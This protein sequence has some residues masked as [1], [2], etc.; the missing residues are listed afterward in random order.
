V[1]IYKYNILS[2]SQKVIDI[3]YV[4]GKELNANIGEVI[5]STKIEQSFLSPKNNLY[6]FNFF[7]STFNRIN[8]GNTIINIIDLDTKKSVRT[9]KLENSEIKDNAYT[10]VVFD[11]ISYSGSKGYT[12][13]VTSEG[14]DTG[15]AITFWTDNNKISKTKLVMNGQVADG[16]LVFDLLY[17]D[18]FNVKEMIIANIFFFLLCI[19]LS[20]LISFLKR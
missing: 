3:N 10:K 19:I 7:L 5:E 13:E 18:T 1:Y 9:V 15:N 2:N 12:I 6:G 20:R 4:M 16:T 14:T 17:E 11:P 8:K